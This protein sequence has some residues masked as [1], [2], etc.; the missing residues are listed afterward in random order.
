M[1]HTFVLPDDYCLLSLYYKLYYKIKLYEET[2][3]LL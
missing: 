1:N 2:I 3:V